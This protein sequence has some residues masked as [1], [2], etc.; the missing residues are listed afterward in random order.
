MTMSAHWATFAL[1]T[2][3]FACMPGPA[4]LYMTSQTLAHGRRAGLQAA[5]GIHLGCFVHI[6]AASAGLAALLH[7]APNLYL[8][9][10]LAG[11]AYLIWLGGSMIFGRRRLG[12]GPG[13]SV[14]AR[15]KVLRDSIIV[16]VLNPKTALFFLTFLPQFVD[17]GAGLPVGLQF[18]ILGMIVNLVFSAADVLAVLFASLLLDMLGEGRGQRLMPRLCG[19]I[20]VGLGVLLVARGGPV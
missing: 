16:E 3:A 12:D 17:A 6:L 15:P 5:L 4:I 19:S 13:Q 11:A 8:A 9:L 18:F 10:K 14:E 1:A 7:H 20:L 2:L